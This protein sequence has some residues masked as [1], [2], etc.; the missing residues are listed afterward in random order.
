MVRDSY[1][2]GQLSVIRS[3]GRAGVPVHAVHEARWVPNAQ[4]RF[5]TP[6]VTRFDRMSEGDWLALLRGLA[7]SL[8][9]AVLIPVDELAALFVDAHVAELRGLFLLPDQPQGLSAEV[10]DKVRLAERCRATGVTTP[11]VFVPQDRGDLER[12]AADTHYPVVLKSRDPRLLRQRPEAASVTIVGSAA[13]L[14]TAYDAMERPEEPN[15]FVQQYLPGATDASW[16]VSAYVGRR[17]DVTV[18]CGRKLRDHPPGRGGTTFAV[19]APNAELESIAGSF[20]QEIGYR[21]IVDMCWRRPVDDPRYHLID[22][23]PRVGANFR[24]FAGTDGNDIVRMAYE[25]LTAGAPGSLRT[26]A[27]RTFVVEPFD[28]WT[29][30]SGDRP[31]AA[32]RAWLAGVRRADERAWAARD[33]F[34]PVLA[35]VAVSAA[36]ALRR[37]LRFSSRDRGKDARSRATR[38]AGGR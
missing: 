19:S 18:C 36:G 29:L 7:R 17:G 14:L 33:D 16:I 3:L 13:E 22:V 8:G 20:L 34:R 4:S 10:A 2:H 6:V 11:W 1:A 35:M 38:A 25:D 15:L 26:R 37:H 31:L 12:F 5:Q 9:H 24:L 32:Y 27:G 30:R 21:G 28:L 23:N